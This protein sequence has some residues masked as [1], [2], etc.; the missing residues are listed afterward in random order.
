MNSFIETLREVSEERGIPVEVLKEAVESGIAVAYK[1]NIG[2]KLNNVRAV[3]DD[4]DG[5]IRIFLEKEIV[6]DEEHIN[7]DLTIPVSKAKTLDSDL[8]IGDIVE[9]EVTPENINRIAAQTAKQVILQKIKDVEKDKL[10]QEFKDKEGEVVVGKVQKVEFDPDGKTI[11]RMMVSLEKIEVTMLRKDFIK[12]DYYRVGDSIK[13]YIESVKQSGKGPVIKLTRT[14]HN[15]IRKMFEMEIPE[16]QDGIIEIKSVAREP[17]VRTKMAVYSKDGNID[18]VGACVGYRGSRIQGILDE[19][20]DEKIDIVR[21][22]SNLADFIVE[23][24]APAKV[25]K[26]DVN[27]ESREAK[28]V[29]P[30]N[31]LSLAIGRDGLNVK[32]AARLVGCR[33]DIKSILQ[34]DG[35]L[36]IFKEI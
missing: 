15:F 35:E 27:G 4:E 1:K 13:V 30:E 31:Q 17:G 36:D 32:L 6:S 2:K 29:V 16:I 28:V 23:A 9:V 26:I 20:H 10:Y 8:E 33:I 7:N 22:K 11:R 5:A 21:W 14:S 34:T 24:I 25:V 12:G 3:L 18:P 19:I